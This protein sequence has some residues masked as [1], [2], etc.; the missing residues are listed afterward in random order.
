MIHCCT[1]NTHAKNYLPSHSQ[2]KKKIDK[3]IISSVEGVFS[4]NSIIVKTNFENTSCSPTN[5][6]P[7][8]A[9]KLCTSESGQ[10]TLYVFF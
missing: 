7:R 10:I 3:P 8:G 2:L 5:N 4:F 1:F 9:Q 6:F